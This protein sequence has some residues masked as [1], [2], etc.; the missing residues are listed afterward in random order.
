MCPPPSS[1]LLKL[2][3]WENVACLGNT[4]RRVP[5]GHIVPERTWNM[6][7]VKVYRIQDLVKVGVRG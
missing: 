1:S 2:M 6:V 4:K 3:K 7:G 5:V